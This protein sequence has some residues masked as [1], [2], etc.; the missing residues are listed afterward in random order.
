MLGMKKG[1]LYLPFLLLSLAMFVVLPALNRSEWVPS[2][3]HLVVTCVCG[4][5]LGALL[6]LCSIR[7][8][9]ESWKTQTLPSTREGR[10]WALRVHCLGPWVLLL[11]ALLMGALSPYEDEDKLRRYDDD[12]ADIA[13]REAEGTTGAAIEAKR[14]AVLSRRQQRLLDRRQRLL[15]RRQGF[16]DQRQRGRVQFLFF[17]SVVV[18]YGLF[19][20]RFRSMLP[21]LDADEATDGT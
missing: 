10:K 13:R 15:D 12:L 3:S 14:G 2:T 1:V 19:S 16:L 9:A 6:A 17:L 8:L 21:E 11:T 20:F 4:V 18:A 7:R 5:I